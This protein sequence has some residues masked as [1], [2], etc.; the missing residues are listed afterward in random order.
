MKLRRGKIHCDPDVVGPVRQ[1]RAGAPDDPLADLV[2]EASLLC[3]RNELAWR[4][5]SARRMPPAQQ[6]LESGDPVLTK[7]EEGLIDQEQLVPCDGA[8]QIQLQRLA[9]A[10]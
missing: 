6:R 2:N 10:R 7:I 5:Q 3:D 1:L 4:D 8:F 9:V